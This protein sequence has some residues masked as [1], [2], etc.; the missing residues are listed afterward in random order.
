MSEKETTVKEPEF[1][2]PVA[3][4]ENPAVQEEK[5]LP[6]T[7]KP[8]VLEETPKKPVQEPKP[9]QE[10]K[11][12]AIIAYNLTKKV[13]LSENGKLKTVPSREIMVGEITKY[14]MQNPGETF[15]IMEYLGKVTAE[16][17]ITETF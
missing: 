3:T 15:M 14:C 8:D 12:K 9:M 7:N 17:K 6:E 11:Q 13:Y 1:V 16:V 2:A 5:S 4:T 10:Q